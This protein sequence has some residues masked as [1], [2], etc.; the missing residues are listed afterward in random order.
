[1][2]LRRVGQGFEISAA[3]PAGYD[4]PWARSTLPPGDAP[5][6]GRGTAA[7]TQPRDATP[8]QEDLEAGD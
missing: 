2:A 8:R 7:R 4:R 1:M 6:A 3:R 5:D